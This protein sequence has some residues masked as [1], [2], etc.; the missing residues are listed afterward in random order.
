MRR[1]SVVLLSL[2]CAMTFAAKDEIRTIL[3]WDEYRQLLK[4]QGKTD[5][6]VDADVSRA[7]GAMK[8]MDRSAGND[9]IGIAAPPFEFDEWLN[10]KPLS[11]QDLR[12][13]VVLIR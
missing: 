1:L 3:S 9:R 6:E 13:Q 2:V 10:S 4:S 7:F 5:A 8:A 12:G 11:L